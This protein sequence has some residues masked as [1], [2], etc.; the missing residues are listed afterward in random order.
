MYQAVSLVYNSIQLLRVNI[1]LKNLDLPQSYNC[2]AISTNKITIDNPMLT[3][4]VFK[5]SVSS[6]KNP[7]CVLGPNLSFQFKLF[8]GTLIAANAISET[9]AYLP[10][11]IQDC[12]LT[13]YP[14]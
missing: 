6:I 4:D 14:N 10:G 1:N 13:F 2:R 9:S 5:V 8:D 12:N 3:S 11:V 7:S